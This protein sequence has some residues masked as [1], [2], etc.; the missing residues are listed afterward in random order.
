MGVGELLG[1]HQAR[2]IV[3]AL[4][5]V[6]LGLVQAEE[7]ELA[8]PREHR[9]RERRLLPLLGVRLQFGD[10]EPVDRL[11]QLLVLLGEDEVPAGGRVVGFD[12]VGGGHR[13]S[14]GLKRRGGLLSK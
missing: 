10:D 8:H 1:E 14:P 5:A 13:I 11:P 9:V 4:A 7:P 3:A 2:V 6:L 12:H